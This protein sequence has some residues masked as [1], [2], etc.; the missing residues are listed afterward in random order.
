MR[1]LAAH[2]QPPWCGGR[3]G[4]PAAAPP[5]RC[6][7]LL[8]ARRHCAAAAGK[9]GKQ[10]SEEKQEEYVE[11][12]KKGGVD[13]ATAQRILDK[14]RE[15]GAESDPSQLRKLFLSQ[16][17]VPIAATAVQLLFDGG[18]AYSIF[19]TSTLFAA[20]PDFW[21]R[22]FAV[23]GLDF[24]A[25][26]FALS[27]FFD[28]ITLTSVVITTA[29]LG[30][31]PQAFYDAVKA[32]AGPAGSGGADGLKIVEKAKAAVSAVKVAS[33]LDAIA[34]LLETAAAGG[35]TR[36]D[37]TKSIDTLSNLSAYVTLYRAESAGGFDP[38]RVG[39]SEAE[40]ANIAL[41]FGQ[42]DLDDNNKLDARE[43]RGMLSALGSD[44][45]E[46]EAAAAMEVMDTDKDSFITFAEFA[47]WWAA[48][49]RSKARAAHRSAAAD[50]R[51]RAQ[52]KRGGEKRVPSLEELLEARDYVGA[53]TL[54]QYKRRGARG[55]AKLAEWQAYAHFHHGEQDKALALYRELL[56]G[57]D[58]DP[59]HHIYAA[60]CCL[61]MGL[62]EEAVEAAS[63]G[64]RCP[65]ATRVLF[66]AAHRRGDED[67]LMAQHGALGDG[68]E[69][70][71]SLAALHFHRGHFQEAAD[72]YKALLLESRDLA[73]LSYHVA[74]CYAKL[75]FYDVSNEL[76]Q[77]YLSSHPT[78]PLSVNLRACN[79]FRMFNGKAAEAELRGLAE[80]CGGRHA[81]AHALVRHNLVVFRGG[82]G[83]MQVLPALG[84]APPEA[85]L[86]LVIHHLRR[87][88]AVVGVLQGQAS[89][90][91]EQLKAAQQAFQVW[92]RAAAG[93]ARERASRARRAAGGGS[94]G[95]VAERARLSGAVP[96]SPP[97]P[98]AQVVGSSASECDTI[99]GRQAMASAYFL[100]GAWEDVL[101]FLN[102]IKSY[103]AGDDTF[104]WNLA[105]ALAATGA[106]REAADALRGITSETIRSDPLHLAWLCR[107]LVLSGR[108]GEAWAAY[109]A[110]AGAGAPGAA[111]EAGYRLLQVIA[112]DCYRA[113]AFLHAL[114]ALDALERLDP[115]PELLE[116]KRGAAAGALQ[117]IVA[118]KLQPELLAEVVELLQA[119]AGGGAG[120]RA[121]PAAAQQVEHMVRVMRA[122][123]LRNGV[124]V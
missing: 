22:P 115:A 46:D 90:S 117:L 88:K 123:G 108:A 105:L 111:G 1:A 61:H 93:L 20:G 116:A 51:R 120:G 97:P 41:V 6:A 54:L 16:S 56:A 23:F 7:P 87:G 57:P 62:L 95:P 3:R 74:L 31:A 30:T 109:E 48:R 80:A 94:P 34:G 11:A 26:Y 113:G 4:A 110:A 8:R 25:I 37:A 89:G 64:P 77:T 122:W 10:A 66:H 42:Y 121:R 81:E 103:F 69:D 5:R 124:A 114:R 13:Q 53:I 12:L 33:A 82:E 99:P 38:A 40:A 18:A 119:S 28:V 65:L 98:P 63:M 59:V 112:G 52:A 49:K 104:A 100:A 72:I 50:A 47:E 78:S 86:N 75:D 68:P 24:L 106:H 60:A 79:A 102:S 96:P 32:I 73:A 44:V 14:W 71:L 91:M 76:L 36:G 2:Q 17:L 45:T 21:G 27:V 15:A 92:P 83:A 39:L 19:M 107:C 67:G 9:D 118:G 85:A 55:D 58:P 70:Q 84:D 101:V 43:F 35:A 29:K